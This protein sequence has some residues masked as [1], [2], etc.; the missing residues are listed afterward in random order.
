[1]S[2]EL[3]PSQELTSWEEVAYSNMVQNEA[4]LRLLVKKG[5]ITKEEFIEE[6]KLVH[7]LMQEN[8][9]Q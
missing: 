3:D 7:Q 8:K 2:D 4:T 9:G 5:I 1:M 6:S